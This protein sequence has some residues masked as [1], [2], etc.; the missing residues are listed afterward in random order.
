MLHAAAMLLGLCLL[1]LLTTQRFNTIEDFAI[2]GA[3]ALM[4]TLIAMRVGGVGAAFARAPRALLT[5]ASHTGAVLRGSLATLRAGLA[6]DVTLTPT[7]VHIRTRGRGAERAAFAHMLSATPG[8][9]VVETDPAGFL[10][11]VINEDEID[12]E[13]LAR[14]ERVTGAHVDGAGR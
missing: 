8:L 2:A 11:H 3:A 12:A 7:L 4:C 5:M 6:A 14:L 9:A 10:V 13:E 1:W